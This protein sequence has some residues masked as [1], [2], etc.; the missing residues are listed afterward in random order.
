MEFIA[1]NTITYLN[2][3]CLKHIFS[4]INHLADIL[5]TEKLHSTI[6]FNI[7]GDQ[8]KEENHQMEA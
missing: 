4:P 5:S 6:A 8:L 2:K 3:P 7:H 1:N